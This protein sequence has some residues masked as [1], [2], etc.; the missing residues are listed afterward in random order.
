[1]PGLFNSIS[2]IANVF[3]ISALAL[4]LL[5][6]SYSEPLTGIDI[7]AIYLPHGVMIGADLVALIQ[8]T[9]LILDQRK[10]SAQ[11]VVP[12]LKSRK[13][14]FLVLPPTWAWF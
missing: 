2:W 6:R 11:S 12:V 7:N 5:T 10:K 14:W 4:G 13:C 3:A 9:R 1:M 8:I